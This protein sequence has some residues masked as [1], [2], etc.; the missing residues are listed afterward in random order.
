MHQRSIRLF[1]ILGFEV[2]ADLSWV[3]LAFLIAWTLA[4]NLFPSDYRGLSRATYW[5]MGILGAAGVFASIIFHELA[6]S[7]VARSR[8]LSIRGIT[9]FI[10]GGVAEMDEEPV[11]PTTEFLMALAGPVSS[12]V[13]G[14]FFY[15][16][17]RAARAG[18]WPWPAVGVLSYL[19]YINFILAA[20]NLAPAFPLDGGR[21]LR[22]ALWRWKKDFRWATGVSA[23]IGS[24]FGAALIFLGMLRVLRGDLIG[25]IWWFLIGMFLRN[26]ARMSYRQ[27]L[28]R[29]AL[30]G[31]KVS[32][33]MNDRPVSVSSALPVA[34]FVDEVLYR[35][36]FKMYPVVDEGKLRGCLLTRRIKEVPRAEWKVQTVAGLTEPCSE[37]NRVRP[38]TDALKALSLM[39]RTQNSRL[40]VAEG[41]RLVGIVTLKDLLRFL[42]IKLDLEG[43]GAGETETP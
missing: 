37:K 34:S 6:H 3:V 24:G 23:R 10:F 27:A 2:K 32:R 20:F 9:L 43:E 12:I 14:S 26:A 36:P 8:G 18:S 31:E 40:L 15:L 19:A 13:L 30:K 5:W 39:D 38:S 42:A 28:M 17:S 41:D 4:E 7:L 33:F 22:A 11:N 1:R 35:H 16:S 25:G 21:V 29:E